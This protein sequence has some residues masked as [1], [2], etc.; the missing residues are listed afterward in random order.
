MYGDHGGPAVGA[1]LLN[2]IPP[3]AGEL[4]SG[5]PEAAL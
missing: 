4:C 3:R 5:Q 1:E 2:L